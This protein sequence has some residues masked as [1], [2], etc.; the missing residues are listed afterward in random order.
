MNEIVPQSNNP[1]VFN[2][3]NH[4]IRIV[5]D[6]N[7]DPLFI[8]SDVCRALGLDNVSRALSRLDDDEKGITSSDTPGGQQKMSVVTESGLYNLIIRS[9][10]PHAK[11]F[12]RWITHEVLPALRKTGVYAPN[13][14]PMQI[15]RQMF[16][17][18]DRQEARLDD[19]AERITSLETHV[20]TDIEY[21][22]V[23]GY[24]RKRGLPAPS[25]N[26][27]Q[28]IGQRATKLS[29]MWSYGIGKTSDPRFGEVNTYHVT[30]LDEITD[31]L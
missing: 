12:K 11:K 7:G 20:Q 4:E 28:S 30:V 25:L 29:R 10:K 1:L 17:A 2:F 31:N 13:L 18:L 9:D 19:H 3:E 26:Q 22:T 16:A 27:A 5:P 8:A 15:L 23:M 24:F 14:S 6:E 21:Y